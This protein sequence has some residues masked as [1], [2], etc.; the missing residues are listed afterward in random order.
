MCFVPYL[1]FFKG[2]DYESAMSFVLEY[3]YIVVSSIVTRV[4][5]GWWPFWSECSH[6]LLPFSCCD[7]GLKSQP[8]SA[9]DISLLTFVWF[10]PMASHV[11]VGHGEVPPAPLALP[12]ESIFRHPLVGPL[13]IC[14]GFIAVGLLVASKLSPLEVV[15]SKL[16]TLAHL[17]VEVEV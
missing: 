3:Y 12:L 1:L 4:Y 15:V 11:P 10:L 7:L 17:D 13:I 9:I 6:C 2:V 14:G 5:N 16:D 8:S